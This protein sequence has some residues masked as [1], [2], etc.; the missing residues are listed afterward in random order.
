[1]DPEIEGVDA[2]VGVCGIEVDDGHLQLLHDF[3]IVHHH[4]L[5]ARN[6]DLPA[7]QLFDCCT[8]I[9]LSILKY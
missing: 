6:L 3:R 1:M 8:G 2:D 4:G 5:A 9:R 7:H